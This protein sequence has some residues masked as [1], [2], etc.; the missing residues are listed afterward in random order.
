VKQPD[1]DRIIQREDH[2]HIIISFETTA[3]CRLLIAIY[4][5]DGTVVWQ[6]QNVFH[7]INITVAVGK[8]S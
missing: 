2:L 4:L 6:A 8:G 7:L 5:T 1:G 3:A